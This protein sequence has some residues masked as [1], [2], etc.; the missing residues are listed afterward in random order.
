M[1]RCGICIAWNRSGEEG[2]GVGEESRWA[3]GG[4]RGGGGGG[5]GGLFISRHVAGATGLD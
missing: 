4:V 1:P 5:Q 3:G 2:E